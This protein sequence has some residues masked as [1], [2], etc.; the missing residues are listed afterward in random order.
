[1]VLQG[2]IYGASEMLCILYSWLGSKSKL[3]R[4]FKHSTGL[5]CALL[6]KILPNSMGHGAFS[7][8]PCSQGSLTQTYLPR[9]H[10]YG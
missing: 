2:G 1:M 3:I 6:L 5:G 9:N 4:S 10:L 8:P 7:Q